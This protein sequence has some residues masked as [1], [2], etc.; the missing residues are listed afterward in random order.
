MNRNIVISLLMLLLLINFV[1]SQGNDIIL[2]ENF[3]GSPTLIDSGLTGTT[4]TITSAK[5]F[6]GPKSLYMDNQNSGKFSKRY[7]L[8]GSYDTLYARYMFLTGDSASSCWNSG[9]HY[10]NMGFEGGTESCK[11]GA[12]TSDGTDCFTVRSRFNWP[13]LGV[14]VES[15]PY[16]GLFDHMNTNV[17]VND[18]NWHC[19]EIKVQLN[20]PS[21]SDGEIRTW[22]DGNEVVKSNLKFRTVGTLKINKWWFTYWANDQWCG[23]LYLDD[24]VISK[25]RIGCPGQQKAATP[26]LSPN[27]GTFQNSVG[28]DL[29]TATAGALV[30]YTKDNSLP[31]QSSTLCGNSCHF[32]LIQSTTLRAKAFKTGMTES[33]E[34]S[35]TFTI[36]GDTT[37]PVRSSGVP[38]GTLPSGTIQAT[39]QVTTNKNANCRYSATAGVQYQ[40]MTNT[41]STTG[42]SSHST[43]LTGLSNGNSYTRF[44]RCKDTSGNENPDDYAIAFS[45]SSTT[46]SC[47]WDFTGQNGVPDGV[48]GMVDLITEVGH[49][50][51]CPG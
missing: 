7:N 49:F 27:G 15:S 11:G 36:G 26:L 25:S 12:Y 32:S 3:D 24:L 33:D 46:N 22:V 48:V 10:K 1:H 45:V 40:S 31:T 5:Y 20:N 44:I 23:P 6:S 19:Y 16:P 28:V 38:T 29:S 9:Q 17:K 21:L 47:P 8:G 30:Y 37:P 43:L 35:A 39:M 42:G 2:S 51:T 41:F 50:G 4:S 14:H 13:Y 34:A 18:G